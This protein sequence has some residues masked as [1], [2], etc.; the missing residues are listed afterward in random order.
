MDHLV[1]MRF[2]TGDH[3]IYVEDFMLNSG[4]NAACARSH[5]QLC[6]VIHILLE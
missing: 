3:G 1:T 2:W 6:N 5:M 4:H